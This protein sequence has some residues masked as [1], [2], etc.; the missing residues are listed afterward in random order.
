VPE[1]FLASTPADAPLDVASAWNPRLV[2]IR[3]EPASQAF[4]T[5]NARGP[6]CSA[7]KRVALSDWLAVMRSSLRMERDDSLAL[8]AM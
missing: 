2:R 4:A 1:R 3:A 7:E 6:W 8:D 5:R